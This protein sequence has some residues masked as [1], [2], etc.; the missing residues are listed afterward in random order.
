MIDLTDSY[1][2]KLKLKP[3]EMRSRIKHYQAQLAAMTDE[4]RAIV[5]QKIR[6]WERCIG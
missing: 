6:E 3:W 2:S 5:Q 1:Y 4:G